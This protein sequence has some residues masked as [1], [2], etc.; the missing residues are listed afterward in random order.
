MLHVGLLK[1][2]GT[3]CSNDKR[4]REVSEVKPENGEEELGVQMNLGE[5]LNLE[6]E[7]IDVLNVCPPLFPNT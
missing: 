1:R 2:L 4:A 3:T 7:R 5:K 6:K